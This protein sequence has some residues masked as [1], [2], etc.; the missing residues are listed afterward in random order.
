MYSRAL[1]PH[2]RASLS[3]CATSGGATLLLTREEAT[4]DRDHRRAA[5]VDGV[6]DLDVVDAREVDRRDAEVAVAQFGVA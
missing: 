1:M 2:P 6:D 3:Q 4:A 5:G